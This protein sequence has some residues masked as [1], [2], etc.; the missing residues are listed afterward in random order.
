MIK[1]SRCLF[2]FVL[3][4]T[5]LAPSGVALAASAHT[6][7]FS[8]PP[9]RVVSLYPNATEVM[10]SLGLSG[11]IAGITLADRGLPRMGDKEVVGAYTAPDLNR[12]AALRPDLVIAGPEHKNLAA[13]LEGMRIP[14]LTLQTRSLKEAGENIRT[15][16]ELFGASGKAQ[17]LSGTQDAWINMAKAKWKRL[18]SGSGRQAGAK[19]MRVLRFLGMSGDGMQVPGDNS[20]QNEMIMAAGGKPP[21][22]GRRGPV[23]TISKDEWRRF[24][25]EAVAFCGMDSAEFREELERDGWPVTAAVA[26]GRLIGFPCETANRAGS[27]YGE[28]ATWLAAELNV[29]AYAVPANQLNKDEVR[30]S[31]QPEFIFP[32]MVKS[33]TVYEEMIFDSLGKTLVIRFKEPQ[34]VL[35]SLEGAAAGISAVGNHYSSPPSWPVLRRL[36]FA[37]S[38][39]RISGLLKLDRSKAAF[40]LTGVDIAGLSSVLS[41]S[42]THKVWV[43]A[44]AGVSGNA[45]NASSAK[46]DYV[47]VGSVNM[48]LVT[49]CT[50]DDVAMRQAMEIMTTAKESAFKDLKIRSAGKAGAAASDWA[51]NI[52]V[53]SG[54]G[55]Q[56]NL[57]D[58]KDKLGDI[59]AHATYQ[60]VDEAVW[61]QRRLVSSRDG[62]LLTAGVSP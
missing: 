16:G 14:V 47:E 13:Q 36:G 9:A 24:N 43:L 31:Y 49:N 20:F 5:V 35:S 25:P 22:F 45:M 55:P 50:M 4:C 60:A 53:V 56:S 28:F 46:G 48:I 41:E 15:L 8:S 29:E 7:R 1:L 19:P 37:E 23:I 17:K 59:I 39:R 11:R 27:H 30:G 32:D 12:I 26:D 58:K 57:N 54:K 21:V 33:A 38:A 18:Y 2:M 42:R 34:R 3:C 44:T 62:N 6:P 52:I 51:D 10:V 40:M 61:N